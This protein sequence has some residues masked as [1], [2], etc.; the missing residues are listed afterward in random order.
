MGP[1]FNLEIAYLLNRLLHFSEYSFELNYI[2][3]LW[4]DIPMLDVI[5]FDELLND[6]LISKDSELLLEVGLLLNRNVQFNQ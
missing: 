3:E 4:V 2:S 6:V 5:L 1:E